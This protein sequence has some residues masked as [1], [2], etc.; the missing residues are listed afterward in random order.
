MFPIL[1]SL[2]LIFQIHPILILDIVQVADA[3]A[4]AQ[5]EIVAVVEGEI[6]YVAI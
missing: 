6:D 3:I 1:Q 2:L 4:V 5:A